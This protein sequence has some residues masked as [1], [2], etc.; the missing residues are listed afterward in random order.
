MAQAG[1][2]LGINVSFSDCICAVCSG[3][4]R[5][6][7]EPFSCIEALKDGE[8]LASIEGYSLRALNQLQ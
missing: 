6:N 2:T 8:M 1:V 3:N 5:Y 4:L 7:I